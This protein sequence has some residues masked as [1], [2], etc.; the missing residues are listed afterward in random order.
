MSDDLPTPDPAKIPRSLPAPARDEA[1][2]H[3]HAELE[4]V[5]DEA[6][7]Q[8]VGRGAVDA[9]LLQPDE[10]R[11]VVDGPSEAIEDATEQLLTDAHGQRAAS[12]LDEGA[13]AESRR[14]AIGKARHT[15][16]AQGH[17]FGEHRLAVAKQQASVADGETYPDD[18]YGHADHAG[19]TAVTSRVGDG[20]GTIA[21]GGEQLGHRLARRLVEDLAHPAERGR[22]IR[23][24]TSAAPTSRTH[25]PAPT[26]GSATI[27][28]LSGSSEERPTDWASAGFK[29]TTAPSVSGD[30]ARAR[31]TA[32]RPGRG[33]L[34]LAGEYRLRDL[35]GQLGGGVLEPVSL[36]LEHGLGRVDS[37]V[38][39]TQGAVLRRD[40][41]FGGCLSTSACASARPHA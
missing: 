22:S 40:G 15:V 7:A 33:E 5:D 18:L 34:Q 32:S 17:D 37:G 39:G 19:D 8:G 29:R 24:S 10:G 14:V 1:V 38:E 2:E 23:A 21:N 3:A 6:P 27:V 41:S 9:D 36:G 20:N 4:L 35:E 25:P 11:P 30:S 16:A 12:V 13:N 26:A 28:K 31:R